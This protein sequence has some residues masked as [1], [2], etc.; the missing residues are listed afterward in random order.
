MSGSFT[1]IRHWTCSGLEADATPNWGFAVGNV[2]TYG[3]TGLML[4]LGSDS[5]PGFRPAPDPAEPARLRLFRAARLGRLQLVCLRRRAGTRR[6]L[7]HLSRRQYV[8]Q[9][10]QRRQ[11]VPGRRVSDRNRRHAR[12]CAH[13]LY[14]DLPLQ[15]VRRP[16]R[17]GCLRRGHGFGRVSSAG[18]TST[19]APARSPSRPPMAASSGWPGGGA[20][21]PWLATFDL[22]L[23]PAS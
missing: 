9:Q 12:R 5:E 16:G 2:Y 4:R 18:Q 7:Q 17:A 23:L 19:A 22:N 20:G 6:R 1:A 21:R 11:E 14:A 3:S 13:G 10:P 8:P 15:G